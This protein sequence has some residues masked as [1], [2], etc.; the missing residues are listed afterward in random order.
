MLK[1]KALRTASPDFNLFQVYS[2]VSSSSCRAVASFRTCYVAAG[3]REQHGRARGG[4]DD[5][6]R[7]WPTYAPRRRCGHGPGLRGRAVPR[8]PAGGDAAGGRGPTERALAGRAAER[9]PGEEET[10]LPG[11]R[12]SGECGLCLYE[13]IGW[14]MSYRPISC[15]LLRGAPISTIF[16]P[17]WTARTCSRCQPRGGWRRPR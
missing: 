1:A 9:R 13:W 4:G 8:R 7:R 5:G 14:L 15:T 11:G 6:A 12:G 16:A 3:P 17:R 10:R 2:I